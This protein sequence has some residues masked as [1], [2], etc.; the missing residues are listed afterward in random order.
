MDN[1]KIIQ[2]KW[3]YRSEPNLTTDGMNLLGQEGWE[4][5]SILQGKENYCCVFKRPVYQ[6]LE[7]IGIETTKT[8]L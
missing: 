8:I 3:E 6:D 7:Q 5:V 1:I 2:V 4:L